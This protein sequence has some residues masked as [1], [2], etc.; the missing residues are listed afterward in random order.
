V[1]ILS[2]VLVLFLLILAGFIS[3]RVKL[4][5]RETAER[6]SSFIINL[7]LPAMLVV[8][9][10]R[11]YD[12]ELLGEAAQALGVSLGVYGAAFALAAL[13]PRLLRLRGPER[14]VH[15]YALIFSNC[16][17]IGY[18]MVEA[19]LGPSLIF[20]A[21]V[22]NIPFNFLAYS[23]GAWCISRE[24]KRA[25]SLSWR[26]FVNPSVIATL[27]GFLI[28]VFSLRL[29]GPLYR[30]LKMLGDM[31]SPLSMIVIGITLSQTK[32]RRI[33]GQGRIYLTVGIRL[34][35]LPALTAAAAYALGIRPPV[36][37][38]A[39]LLT[40]MPAGSTTSILASLYG[41]APEEGSS[42]VF[43]STLLCVLTVPLVMSALKAAL[44]Q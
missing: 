31:T 19:L 34:L 14:G 16:A 3:A 11:P 8:S 29:P 10:A 20:H 4:A 38:L 2:Q 7:S 17:F 26:T 37:T 44:G 22:Y 6:F 28:F 40:A 24:G 32:L 9:F 1:N 30:S 33:F 27:L 35:A 42:L 21:V 12:R 13:Y 18:P 5:A 23:L 43:L 36:L 15:R 39:V 41:V 25:L